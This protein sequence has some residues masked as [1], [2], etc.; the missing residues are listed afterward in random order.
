MEPPT[1]NG[2][3]DVASHHSVDETVER[4]TTILHAK[5]VTL[6]AVIDHSAARTILFCKEASD[7]IA[8][9]RI[10]VGNALH[11]AAQLAQGMIS[12]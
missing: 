11:H 3:V 2:I 6:F 10:L 9:L 4:L 8:I 5:G 1:D 7:R 12:G